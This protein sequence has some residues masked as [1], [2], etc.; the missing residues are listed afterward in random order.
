M[1]ENNQTKLR[2]INNVATQ[3]SS[4]G[5]DPDNCMPKAEY[6][7]LCKEGKLTKS[8]YVCGEGICFPPVHVY[9]CSG[10]GSGSGEQEILCP[11][12]H[13]FHKPG[14]PCCGSADNPFENSG[15]ES[16]DKEPTP[17]GG[18]TTSGGGSQGGGG[19]N[20]TGTSPGNNG[21]AIN[22]TSP[23][24]TT[25]ERVKKETGLGIA[26]IRAVYETEAAG[27][28]YIQDGRKKILYERH[29]FHKLTNG[30][31]D[32]T[33]PDISSSKP[34]TSY[35]T[36]SEQ[37][38][39]FEKAKKLDEEAAFQSI[40]YGAFQIMGYNYKDAG[41][42]TA[43]DFGETMFGATIDD[44]FGIFAT[45][46][47]AKTNRMTLNALIEHNWAEFAR[48]YNGPDFKKNQYDTK[49]RDN[50]LKYE[51]DPYKGL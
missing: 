25:L 46:I 43:K 3:T 8:V 49:M 37:Y 27:N 16:G 47:T 44:M 29:V 9:G 23:S 21:S 22:R 42:N 39:R 31:Y 19:G 1:K 40:S 18:G 7:R 32:D 5:S 35:G 41:F 6:E 10:S 24:K 36:Y 26:E 15:E 11:I 12:C 38:N 14:E 4:T 34:Y 28:I 45:F 30:R 48:L 50:Y 17:G 13:I 2:R 20:S 51:K 33:Y